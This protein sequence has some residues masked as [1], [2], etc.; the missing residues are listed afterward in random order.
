MVSIA[1]SFFD[2]FEDKDSIKDAIIRKQEEG[3][4]L[5]F[6]QKKDRSKPQLDDKDKENF[7]DGLSM[8][9]NSDGGVQVWGVKTKK[10]PNDVATELKPINQ[11]KVFANNLQEYL[12]DA[13]VPSVDGVIIKEIIGAKK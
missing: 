7:A 11:V 8:F 2:S 5:E 10:S 13:V 9:T 12:K 4:Y 1:Q 6:K 3:L